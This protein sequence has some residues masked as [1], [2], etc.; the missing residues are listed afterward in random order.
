M[1]QNR[2]HKLLHRLIL[3]RNV[4]AKLEVKRAGI[5]ISTLTKIERGEATVS[6]ASYMQ[7]F[8]T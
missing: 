6:L 1:A 8:V 5:S 3:R 4:T 7:V 2:R